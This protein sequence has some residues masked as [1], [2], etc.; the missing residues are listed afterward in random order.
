MISVL[1]L[2]LGEK[3][4]G[5]AGC[6]RLGLFA[7]GLTTIHRKSFASDIQSLQQIIQERSAELLVIGLPYTMD[8]KLGHQA[9]RIQK[10]ARRIATAVHLPVE[11]MD[12][13]LTSFEAEQLISAQH[14]RTSAKSGLIDRKAAALILQ[15]WL[16]QKRQE[17]TSRA[18]M[19]L[20]L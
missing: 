18:R 20:D 15:Q 2:D 19:T 11:Y 3:R 9:K 5:V 14:R 17:S 12:E 1:G 10:L 13:R 7:T 16:D 6:D 4:I 8:G